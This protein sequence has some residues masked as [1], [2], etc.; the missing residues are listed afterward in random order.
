[1]PGSSHR[2][3]RVVIMDD[4][5]WS[6]PTPR[7]RRVLESEPQSRAIRPDRILG[8]ESDA[9]VIHVTDRA[10]AREADREA[11]LSRG[12]TVEVDFEAIDGLE[13]SWRGAPAPEPELIELEELPDALDEERIWGP[14]PRLHAD[15][16]GGRRTVVITGHVT[17]R[18]LHPRTRSTAL[19][20]GRG[21]QAD[22]TAMWAVL[23]CV[24]LLL[25]AITSH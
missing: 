8:R 6:E 17:D 14:R 25:V 18:Q 11:A 16:P 13:R 20:R 5:S 3:G 10:W 1:M 23:L 22:R 19:D 15:E 12:V 9:R 24:I 2:S 21:L 7:K 4:V